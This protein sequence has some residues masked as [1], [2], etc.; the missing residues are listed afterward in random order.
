M[1]AVVATIVK[2]TEFSGDYKLKIFTFTP[3]SS[4]DTLDLS[5]YFSEIVGADAHLTA[6]LDAELTIL[7]TSF[8]T[9]TVTVKQLKADGATAADNWTSGA[10]EVWVV[11]K[12][13]TNAGS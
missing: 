7:Q 3:A 12:L 10:V 9:T 2:A 13:N 11:G 8:A 5:T 4:S 1:G 6:G